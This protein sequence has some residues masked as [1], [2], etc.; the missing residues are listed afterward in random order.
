MPGARLKFLEAS[1]I[2]P[3]RYDHTL[4]GLIGIGNGAGKGRKSRT[5]TVAEERHRSEP[6]N[7]F[8]AWD[9]DR[10]EQLLGLTRCLVCGIHGGGVGTECSL[11][12]RFNFYQN[13]NLCHI[14]PPLRFY[15]TLSRVCEALDA[16]GYPD[17]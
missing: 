11:L 9:L 6:R 17:P 15:L 4:R 5:D 2:D 8:D 16:T 10:V 14:S 13:V 7:D 12:P 3:G 1:R